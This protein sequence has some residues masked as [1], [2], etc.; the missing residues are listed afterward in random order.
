MH[1]SPALLIFRCSLRRLHSGSQPSD[2]YPLPV[3]EERQ[4]GP[5]LRGQRQ[6]RHLASR[7]R[8]NVRFGVY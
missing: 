4:T 7:E 2:A 6:A 5:V 3:N 1:R 8:D